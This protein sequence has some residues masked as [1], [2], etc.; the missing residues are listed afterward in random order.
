MFGGSA[1]AYD[2][3]TDEYYLHLF[4][5]KQPDLNWDNPRVRRDI[6][7]MMRWWLDK[8][9]DG[10]RMDVINLISKDMRMPCA[11]NPGGAKYAWGG[12]YFTDGPRVHEFLQEMY[13]SVLSKYDIMTVGETGGV[14]IEQ[15][16][17]YSGE[18][19]RELNMV[20][21]FDHM[22]LDETGNKWNVTSWK[23]SDLKQV[24][25]R[26]QNELDGVAW[27][28]LYLNNH[29][30][31]RS[32]SRFG[33]DTEYRVESAKMLATFLHMHQG[34]PFIYQGEEI[35]MTNVAFEHIDEY[36]DLEIHNLW[37][38]RVTDG[39]EDPGV[40]MRAIHAKG[41]DNARTPMQW[42]GSENGGF[43]QADP[44]IKVN[45]NYTKINV[46][47]AQADPN[48]VLNYYRKLIGL[49]KSHPIM[50]YG[51]YQLIENGCSDIYAFTRTLHD[52]LWLVVCNFHDGFRSFET[53]TWIDLSGTEVILS[54]YDGEIEALSGHLVLKPFEARCYRCK[55]K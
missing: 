44:W 10:F 45:P 29:D 55:T 50:V 5:P 51:K 47:T 15:A 14:T 37:R 26:W 39:G 25:S 52:E 43:S 53:P 30:Q 23:L 19:R 46:E 18:E 49:R 16:K 1:W 42:N 22:A 20:F 8:G 2:E 27:N 4:S 21:Q 9:I 35:G 12:Q 54:N 38:D 40:V 7:D 48:S 41:R 11:P 17:L 6:F 32:V 34:T 3:N 13:E 36:K 33:N 28:S 24:M 31:P